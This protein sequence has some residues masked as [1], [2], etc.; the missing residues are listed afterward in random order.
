MASSLLLHELAWRRIGGRL[1]DFPGIDPLVFTDAGVVTCA[2]RP[3]SPDQVRPDLVWYSVDLFVSPAR[4]SFVERMRQAGGLKW[5]QVSAAGLDHAVFPELTARGV[6]L[7]TSHTHAASVAEFVVAGVL[8]HYQRGRERRA[9]QSERVW[10]PIFFREVMG[11]HWLIVGFGS[12]GRCVAARAQ[13]FGA[14]VTGIR[15]TPAPDGPAE[16]IAPLSE[17]EHHVREADVVVLSIPLSAATTHL[18]GEDFLRAMK[19][20]S[21]L[22]NVG[23]GGLVDEAALLAALD[24]GTPEHAVLDV[25][26]TEPL[27][28]DHP[29]WAHP[30]VALSPHSAAVTPHLYPRTDELF[31]DN[32]R[33]FLDG[34]DLLHEA[35]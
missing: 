13:A 26:E 27:P 33:R 8:D 24:R 1:K 31:L 14:T 2:D 29:F 5:V 35:R 4:E 10:R 6:R 30:R 23:R 19:P 28:P 3:L 20:G 34:R 9:Q 22:V 18:V 16:R 32:L 25:F 21:T 17:L 11:T 12:I 7:T 15:R